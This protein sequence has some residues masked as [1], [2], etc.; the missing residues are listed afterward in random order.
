MPSGS[1]EANPSPF[2]SYQPSAV[3]PVPLILL[4]PNGG[5]YRVSL[6]AWRDMHAAGFAKQSSCFLFV[7][8]MSG[9]VLS[10]SLFRMSS[11]GLLE[12][13]GAGATAGFVG[14]NDTFCGGFFASG[15]GAA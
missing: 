13:E 15:A 5:P 4:G 10:S 3:A 9:N 11:H 14:L 7:T 8:L 12:A 2:M 6:P 1:P